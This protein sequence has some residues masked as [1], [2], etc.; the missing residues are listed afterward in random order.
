MSKTPRI[1]IDSDSNEMIVEF[2]IN[3]KFN[4]ETMAQDYESLQALVKTITA[5]QSDNDE[6]AAMDNGNPNEV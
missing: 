2:K 4:L 5:F 3:H 6:L 1:E